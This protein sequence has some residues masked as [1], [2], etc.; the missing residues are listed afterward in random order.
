[1]VEAGW[2]PDPT[3]RFEYRYWD[4]SEWST[5]VSRH[6]SQGSD[7]VTVPPPPPV[8][9][10]AAPPPP[11]VASWS[12]PP[13]VAPP[14][15]PWPSP[16]PASSETGW[17]T[18]IRVAVFGAAAALALGSCLRWVKAS[19]GGFTV[20][21]NGLSGD[22]TL[23]LTI[24]VVVTLLFALVKPR[25]V[26]ATLTIV[27]GGIAAAITFYDM[28]NIKQRASDLS[29]SSI[30]VSGTIGIG[31]ILAAIAAVAIVIVGVVG[32]SEARRN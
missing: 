9:S 28:V 4:G 13:G 27:F 21:R 24:A 32:I 10:T 26:A 22:G 1:M 8:A 15:P 7:P 20:T 30:P 11:P 2:L 6:G 14:P 25:N 23:T 16:A 12:P 29:T 19:A 3:G 31:L 17:S 5:Y 18:A